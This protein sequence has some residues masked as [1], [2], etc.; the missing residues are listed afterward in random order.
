MHEVV[1]EVSRATDCDHVWWLWLDADE[2]HHGPAGLTLREHLA[3]LD[4]QVRVVG[5]RMY[6]HYP[7]GTPSNVE[8]HH[9]LDH[10]PLCVETPW[11]MCDALHRKH[12][13]VRWD[14]E[15]PPITVGPGFHVA[16][17]AE[18]PLLEAAVPVFLHHFPFRDEAVS[19]RRLQ[20]LFDGPDGSGRARD[21]EAAWH[22]RERWRSFDAVYA[23]RWRRVTNLEMTGRAH[24]VRPR[25]WSSQVP[26]A[27]VPVARWYP[28]PEATT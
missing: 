2:F 25:P 26:T 27:D 4:R 17:S 28:C 14:R 9:P 8:G 13:L 10:Q 18:R 20:T 11:Y 3:G 22:M 19:R 6:D 16:S 1:E 15:G 24:G 23:G 21:D 5:A 7:S 12:P